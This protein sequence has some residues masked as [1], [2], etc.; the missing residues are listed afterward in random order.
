MNKTK[1]LIWAI[2]M[3]AVLNISTIGSII[4][5]NFQEKQDSETVILNS[6]SG[7]RING[8]YFRQ[9]LG[10]NQEQM[11]AFRVANREFQPRANAI[12]SQIDSLKNESFIELKKE[13]SDTLKLEDLSN[14]TG[15]LHA[16][17]K[18]TTNQFYLKIKKVCTAKQLDELQFVFK[19]FFIDGNC[20]GNGMNGFRNKHRG[21]QNN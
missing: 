16:E 19:P 13:N 3:L 4:Y 20:R 10:F 15:L 21:N 14:K 5:H 17:L 8:R 7:S 18:K 12:I 11:N 9:T 1:I 6:E 2:V